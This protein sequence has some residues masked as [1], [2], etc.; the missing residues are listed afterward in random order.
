MT[1]N[2]RLSF[3]RANPKNV[4][5]IF[6]ILCILLHSL[7]KKWSQ[8]SCP[9]RPST[10]PLCLSQATQLLFYAP[11]NV[12]MCF[13]KVSFAVAIFYFSCTYCTTISYVVCAIIGFF[14][15]SALSCATCFTMLCVASI[16]YITLK[17]SSC[18]GSIFY[19]ILHCSTLIWFI[20]CRIFLFSMISVIYFDG[21]RVFIVYLIFCTFSCTVCS[22]CSNACISAFSI[23]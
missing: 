23:T 19:A 18:S 13:S 10:L 12:T 20:S 9:N 4:L 1:S 22:L 5:T 14:K 6:L 15:F 7:L 3:V 16:F 8:N 2:C 21:G 17:A 11:F